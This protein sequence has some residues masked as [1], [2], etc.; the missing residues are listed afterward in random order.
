MIEFREADFSVDEALKEL[1][2]PEI[3]AVVFY[4][5]VVRNGGVKELRKLYGEGANKEL[6]ELEKEA[7]D[8]F[9]AERILL[10]LRP[11]NLKV[12]ENVLLIGVSATHR[13]EAFQAARFLIDGI[14]QAA[15]I[16]VEEIK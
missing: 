10:I 6:E 16:Q 5:G 4:V 13:G 12:E 7:K 14:K 1:K 8:R 9:G 2:S 3:G 15:S 11:G